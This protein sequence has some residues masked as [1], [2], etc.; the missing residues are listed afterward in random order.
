M[1]FSGHGG[2]GLMVG[3]GDLFGFF[4]NLNDPV[5]GRGEKPLTVPLSTL[6]KVHVA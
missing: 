1:M 2:D 5:I 6:H 4:S 3:L